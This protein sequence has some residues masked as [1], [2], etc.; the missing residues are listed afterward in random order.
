MRMWVIFEYENHVLQNI[1]KQL[2]DLRVAKEGFLDCFAS[3]S[4]ICTKIINC[5]YLCIPMSLI[6][7]SMFRI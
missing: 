7:F 1:Y 4:I 2:I 5:A 6:P 3:A